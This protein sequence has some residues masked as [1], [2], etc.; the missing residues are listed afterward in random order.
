MEGRM[1]ARMNGPSVRRS[2][3]ARRSVSSATNTSHEMVLSDGRETELALIAATLA[4]AELRSAKATSAYYAT[5]N[6][7]LVR[8]KEKL[9]ENLTATEGDGRT[10]VEALEE[11]L[12][13]ANCESTKL[14]ADVEAARVAGR[15]EVEREM[16]A[17]QDKLRER[18]GTIGELRQRVTLLEEELRGVEEFR[19][20]RD[21]HNGKMKAL[22]KAYA[23]EQER[24]EQDT[25]S[26]RIHLMGERVRLRA[27]EQ[28]L[29]KRHKD[30][31]QKLAADLFTKKKHKMGKQ[32][33]KLLQERVL[34]ATETMSARDQAEALQRRNEKL[35]QDVVLA[36]SAEME[37]ATRGARQRRE[38]A[39]LREQVK[40]AED[41]LNTVV[42][43]YDK[44]LQKQAKEHAAAVKRLT[45]ERDEA[46]SSDERLRREL[47]KLRA[48]SR[49]IVER[50]SEL[51]QF[52]YEALAHVRRELLEERLV[53]TR[54]IDCQCPSLTYQRLS[55]RLQRNSELLLIS[56][57]DAR[58]RPPQPPLL[59]TH[60]SVEADATW[61]N[62]EP[63]LG[64][65]SLG[66]PSLPLIAVPRGDIAFAQNRLI[67][68]KE[69]QYSETGALATHSAL[70]EGG[71]TF[72]QSE[73]SRIPS[74]PKLKDLQSIEI[75]QL[76]WKDKERV[77]HILFKQL[78]GRSNAAKPKQCT[79]T[80]DTDFFVSGPTVEPETNTFLTESAQ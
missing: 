67:P 25:R 69:W 51:E 11:R 18:D 44:R 38:I 57:R 1:S 8:E 79:A 4:N 61:Q 47:V 36:A 5:S 10:V 62:A 23:D 15:R 64:D 59:S 42:E 13:V 6:E 45:S 7:K 14:R 30:D 53:Q 60:G 20:A 9:E 32:N 35:E 27:E 54:T 63:P 2:G 70:L 78:Q 55:P 19:A 16:S 33:E 65:V 43:Q 41:N 80:G 17:L 68:A 28:L 49:K 74:A 72:G 31:V 34:L 3:G 37:Y 24:H 56:D 71:H 58:R 66:V 29:H 73:F 39:A 26:L 75:S 22:Q 77:L 76:S 52:F 21:T 40:T 46:R 50:R 12:R 48:L